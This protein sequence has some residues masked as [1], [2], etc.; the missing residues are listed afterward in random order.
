M[1][2]DA[3]ELHLPDG[4]KM[5]W[6][7]IDL[8]EVPERHRKACFR[9]NSL[10]SNFYFGR[11][12]LNYRGFSPNLHL[13]MARSVER[14]KIKSVKEYPRGTF[15]TSLFSITTPI[16]WALP[17]SENDEGLMRGLG[18]G[19]EWIRWMKRAHDQNTS[20]LILSETDDNA[21]KIGKEISLHYRENEVFRDIFSEILPDKSA[22]WNMSSMMHRRTAVGREGT[23]ELAGVGKTLQSRHYHR[24]ISDDLWGEDALYSPTEAERTISFHQKIPGLYRPDQV[25]PDHIGDHL[26]V[27]NRWGVNDLNGWIKKNQPSYDFETHAIDGGCCPDH[28]KGEMILP[29]FFSPAKIQ[30]LRESFGPTGFAAQ[31]LNNPLDE[32]NRIFR[33]EWLQHYSLSNVL[34]PF[35]ARESDGSI[36]LLTAIQHDTFDG[37]TEKDVYLSQLQRFIILD[38]AHTEDAKRGRARHAIQT[39]GYLPGKKPRF[40]ILNSW[41]KHCSYSE[42][43]DTVFTRARAWKVPMVWV[44]VLA[45]QDGWMYLLRERNNNYQSRGLASPLRI[46]PLKKDRSPDAKRRR[47]HATEPLF[48]DHRVWVNRMDSGYTDFRLEYD[49]YESNATIDL[50]DTFGY[51]PQCVTPNSE[52]REEGQEWLRKRENFISNQMAVGYSS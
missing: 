46:E 51:A 14:D 33:D 3:E 32:S 36:K 29:E 5:K 17:F 1:K 19:D 31:Y 18:Y 50:L 22:T 43:I 52:T 13:H 37:T 15:K 47:I 25:R 27:G 9:L 8:R 34:H 7:M 20:T 23:Y 38:P 49:A 11:G 26:V 4:E 21:E 35:G 6:A 45:G 30:E 10:G 12:V 48:A 41:A 42:M 40:Y 39:I 44:E 16:W 2:L 24:I 28:P